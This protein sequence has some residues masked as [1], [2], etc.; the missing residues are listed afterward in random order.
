MKRGAGGNAK[1]IKV[2]DVEELDKVV[3]IH[4]VLTNMSRNYLEKW[5]VGRK[6]LLH[7]Q[8]TLSQSVPIVDPSILVVKVALVTVKS[9]YIEIY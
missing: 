3:N 7:R 6:L 4:R 8:R 1:A 5:T 2:K 9:N